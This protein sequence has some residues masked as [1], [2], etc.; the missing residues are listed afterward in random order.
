MSN[1]ND[2]INI[3]PENYDETTP[4]RQFWGMNLNTYCMLMNL[5]QILPG[6]GWI[7]AILM[8][9]MNKDNSPEINRY[10]KN[11]TNWIISFAIFTVVVGMINLFIGIIG[12]FLAFMF[13]APP[14][15][16]IGHLSAFFTF[17]VLGIIYLAFP[18]TAAVK[19]NNGNFWKYPLS[20]QFFK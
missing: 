16:F 7:I 1:D 17:T 6:W 20:I 3:S 9:I 13:Q 19:A 11:V 15:I 18:I 8:W 10:G 14:F 5:I 12:A 2:S 4:P